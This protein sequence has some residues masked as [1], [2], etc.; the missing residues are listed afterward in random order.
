MSNF[1]QKLKKPILTLAPMEDVTDY[2]F[3]ETL[4]S[5]GK[6]DVM[7]TEFTNCTG[8]LHSKNETQLKRLKFSENQRLIVAQLWG[9]VPEEF[10]KC[11]RLI[12]Q[13]GFDGVDV[14]MGCPQKKVVKIG[15]G[16]GLISTKTLVAEIISAV[17]EGAG[18]IGVSV[19]TRLGYSKIDTQ[20]WLGFL[21]SN[22]LDAII[23]H[24]RIATE[25][26]R[27]PADWREIGKVV[28]LRNKI[29]P[30][31]IIIGNGDV[32]SAAQA[33]K[34]CKEFGADGAM[35]GRAVINNPFVFSNQPDV[36][37]ESRRLNALEFHF[38][39]FVAESAPKVRIK[40]FYKFAKMYLSQKKV[41]RHLYSLDTVEEI[42]KYILE[43]KAGN[44]HTDPAED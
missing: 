40:D 19:K 10:Y 34:L 2:A 30:S 41:L 15:A 3:R 21:L 29:S 17:K 44:A 24:A 37:D 26:S 42:S 5:I 14:N 27:K 11:A 32:Q 8:L 43:L 39:T 23:V 33:E 4:A 13:M 16:A 6:P 36:S 20:D 9:T 31:T 25:M 18:G 22:N 28:E 1:W 7:F 12:K 35:L 38:K